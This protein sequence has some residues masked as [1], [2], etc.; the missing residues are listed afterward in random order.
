VKTKPVSKEK[1]RGP[2][3][4]EKRERL[5]RR[6]SQR[7]LSFG[8]LLKNLSAR[9]LS[10]FPDHVDREIEHGL[11]EVCKFFG[12]SHCILFDVEPNKNLLNAVYVTAEG[13]TQPGPMLEE[14]TSK[15]FPWI[16][17]K[18]IKNHETLSISRLDDLPPDANVDKQM[19]I[20]RGVVSTLIIPIVF[21][22]AVKYVI[23]IYSVDKERQWPQEIIR[24]LHLLGGLFSGALERGRSSRRIEEQLRFER[25]VSNLSSDFVGLSIDKIDSSILGWL[26][27]LAEF[28][29]VDRCSI[30]LFSDD[31][32]GMRFDYYV[33]VALPSQAYARK[34]QLPWY[35]QQLTEGKHVIINRVEDLPPEA[36]MEHRFCMSAGIKSLCSIPLVV[37]KQ[38]LGSF[39]FVSVHAELLWPEN[40]IPRLRLVGEVFASALKRRQ[41]QLKLE[42]QLS[43]ETLLSDISV[44]FI[45]LPIDQVDSEIEAAQRLVCE[46]LDLDISAIFLWS[47]QIRRGTTM[48]YLYQSPGG[49]PV[50]SVMSGDQVFPWCAEQL[51]AGR[52]VAVSSTEDV[53]AEAALDREAWRKFGIKSS[54][55][56]PLTPGGG[57]PIG[58][59]GFGAIRKKCIWPEPLIK[60]LQLVAQIF[61]SAIIRKQN[62]VI[63]RTSEARLSM[64]TEAV[65][66]GL[67]VME[68]DSKKV[69]LSQKGRELYHFGPD[70]EIDY[71]NFFQVIHPDDRDGFYEAL[72]NTIQSGEPL[73][74]DH[75]IVLPDGSFRWFV[76]R[77]RCFLKSMGEPDRIM[78]LSLDITE[79]KQMEEKVRMAMHGWQVTFDSIPDVIIILDQN[80]R[81]VMANAAAGSFLGF[82]VKNITGQYCYALIHGRD[83]PLEGCCFTELMRSKSHVETESYDERRHVWLRFSVDPILDDKGEIKQVVHTIKDITRQK[84]TEIDSFTTRNALQ[85]TDRLMQMGEL[86]A[87]LAH[88]LNQPL[89]SILSNARAALRFL[90]SNNLDPEELTEILQDIVD[91]DKRAGNIIRSLRSMVRPQ[92]NERE[93][94]LIND[95]VQEV[96]VLFHSEAIIRRI[97]VEAILENSSPSVHVDRVQIQQVLINMMMNAVD[98]MLNM[99]TIR[100][101]I[102]QT[103]T[104][105]NGGVLVAVRDFGHGIAEKELAKIFEPFFTTKH[106]GLGMGLSLSRSIVESHGGHIWAENNADGGTTFFFDL[107][108]MGQK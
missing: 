64:A 29:S 97:K 34:E 42:E 53:P 27:T 12:C 103:Q 93:S 59:I 102:I 71:E 24:K 58:T 9:F 100:T 68:I 37:G 41:D 43:F 89:T 65:E 11:K 90:Q 96:I 60:R 32:K 23:I 86:T 61:A 66:A 49:L 105:S 22:E 83:K 101:I 28:F 52:I 99:S 5:S 51:Q 26:R 7:E 70:E 91:D 104:A 2:T 35:F 50:P 80:Q 31:L 4:V 84:Q 63:L 40:L 76:S 38:I 62:E 82:S 81:I 13:D 72:R 74:C 16:F 33:P 15:V 85:R 3:D 46:A 47:T 92:E 17:E 45:N 95:V 75:R 10:V 25:L 67:W 78:C 20:E 77:G 79:R 14:H 106:G 48:A 108:A 21:S 18:V 57:L 69:W 19:M 44:R 55:V 39:A 54:L 73:H 6:K 8:I 107:P 88:E 56:F 30:G 1:A 98:S 87:S 36:E 94:V